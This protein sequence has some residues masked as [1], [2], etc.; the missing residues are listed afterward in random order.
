MRWAAGKRPY[1]AV[2]RHQGWGGY[3][4]ISSCNERIEGQRFRLAALV[5]TCRGKVALQDNGLAVLA[6]AMIRRVVDNRWMP[7]LAM[8]GVCRVINRNRCVMQRPFV[9]GASIRCRCDN[10]RVADPV[11]VRVAGTEQ[12]R[13]GLGGHPVRA[14]LQVPAGAER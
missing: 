7:K 12:R 9:Y 6:R 11:S 2:S 10:L 8:V 5:E 4:A 14:P 13:H 1:V 3:H